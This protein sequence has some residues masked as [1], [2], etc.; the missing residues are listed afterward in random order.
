MTPA[1]TRG[2]LLFFGEAGCVACHSVAGSSNEMFSDFRSHAIAVPQL[3]PAT[4]NNQF[5][6][7]GANEDFGRER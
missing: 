5:D 1:E 7:P 6:G 3:V 2:A 4:T